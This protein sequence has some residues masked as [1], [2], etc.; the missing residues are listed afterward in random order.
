MDEHWVNDQILFLFYPTTAP[1]KEGS[2]R[3]EI[4]S[5]YCQVSFEKLLRKQ[6]TRKKKKKKK[7]INLFPS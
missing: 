4:I 6:R 2:S 5:I 3:K 1:K 7:L